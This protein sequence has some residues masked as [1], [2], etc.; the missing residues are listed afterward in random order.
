MS[1]YYNENNPYCAEWIRNL[2]ADGHI[3]EGDAV[4][5]GWPTPRQA[6]GEKNVLTLE[7]SLREIARKGGVQDLAQ[8]DEWDACAPTE[9]RSARRRPQNLSKPTCR[10]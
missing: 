7:G 10:D 8:P 9:T 5:A 3:A 6:D 4:L 2:I 1:S